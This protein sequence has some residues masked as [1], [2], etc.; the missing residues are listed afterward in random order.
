VRAD[1]RRNVEMI[2]EA[3]ERCLA[4]DPDASMSDIASVA[5]LGR[6]TIYGH[7][8]SRPEL[9][10]AVARRVLEAVASAVNEL[11]LSG[12]PAAALERLVEA[13]W[14]LTVRSGRLL[15]AAEKA[16]PAT[17]VRDLHGGELERLIRRFIKRAQ[18]TGAFRT[19]LP[20]EWL[21]AALHAIV[22]AAANEVEAGRLDSQRAPHVITETMLAIYTSAPR[23]DGG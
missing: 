10:E 3:A 4:R 5:G 14:A 15:I 19:D 22:H 20:T 18:R 7:F 6:V 8:N 12:D 17:L 16:L 9:I 21:V 23:D 13:T 11:D 2:L 1:A